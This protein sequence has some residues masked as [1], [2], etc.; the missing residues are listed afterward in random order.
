MNVITKSGTNQF[1]GTA[2]EFFRNTD[3]NA[4]DFFRNQSPP[5]NG[6]PN[7]SRQ[8]LN[9][10]QYGGVIGGPIKKDKLF[11]L[12]SYQGTWQKNG[13]GA[14]GYSTPVLPPLPTGDRSNVAAFTTALANMYCGQAG[15]AAPAKITSPTCT[16]P[17]GVGPIN[18]N[19]VAV[20]LLELKNLDGTYLIQGS[21]TGANQTTT[22]S[23]P[24]LFTERQIAGNVDLLA[25]RIASGKEKAFPQLTMEKEGDSHFRPRVD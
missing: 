12:T 13:V 7:N 5:I 23:I 1:H 15:Q 10:N 14:Q 25:A 11:F 19:P 16:N 21:S 17:S 6:V 2:F 22:F 8:V 20:N 3:L 4:N 24:A 18:I 9:Q